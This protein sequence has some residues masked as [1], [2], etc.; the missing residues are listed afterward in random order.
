[1]LVSSSQQ[2]LTAFCKSIHLLYTLRLAR[3]PNF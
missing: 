3:K 1:L 2:V